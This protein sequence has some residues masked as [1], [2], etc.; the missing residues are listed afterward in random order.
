MSAK[1]EKLEHEY[2]LSILH[3]DEK[4]GLFTWKNKQSRNVKIGQ[5]AGYV[6]GGYVLITIKNIPYLGHRLAWFYV[7][8][9]WPA[10]LVDHTDLNRANNKLENLRLASYQENNL[11]H[12]KNKRNLL[13]V[14]G[15]YYAPHV[16]KYGA[17]AVFKGKYHFLG[18]YEQIEFASEAYKAFAKAHHGEFY[19]DH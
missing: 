14:R 3:Y 19:N 15:V 9:E 16:K 1:E 11:N 2:L 8:G 18:Y 6:A 12:S 10:M 7:Y 4:T 5:V 13:G 17:R